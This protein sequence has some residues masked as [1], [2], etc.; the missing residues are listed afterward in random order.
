MVK[1]I[2]ALS[3]L[4]VG[5]AAC[6]SGGG[7]SAEAESLNDRPAPSC[8]CIVFSSPGDDNSGWHT[9]STDL[10][11]TEYLNLS[12]GCA[13]YDA[14]CTLIL[15]KWGYTMMVGAANT[16]DKLMEIDSKGLW[17]SCK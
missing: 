16:G 9:N 11:D 7:A 13:N 12:F 2:L 3:L 6:G 8:Q 10:C 15:N 17:V 14:L 5:L 1:R 4:M